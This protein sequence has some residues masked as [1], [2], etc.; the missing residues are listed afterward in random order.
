MDRTDY[1]ILNLLQDDSRCTLRRMGD[2]VGLTPPAVSERIRRMEESGVIRGYHIDIDRTKLDCNITGFISVALEPDKYDKFCDFC[3]S[4]SAVISHYH[5]VGEFNA[6]LRFAVRDTQ[7]LD[8]LLSLIKKFGDS[9]T[10]IELKTLLT[11]RISLCRNGIFPLI[12]P[13]N[14]PALFFCISQAV[15]SFLPYSAHLLVA[16]EGENCYTSINRT[17]LFLSAMDERRRCACSSSKSRP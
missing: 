13:A 6:L 12:K 9:R 14:R 4:Q 15:S 7:Q 1:Q 11:A 16:K 3:S 10:S 8:Q 2:L 5:V 17:M